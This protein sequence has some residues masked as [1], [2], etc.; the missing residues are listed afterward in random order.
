MIPGIDMQGRVTNW[1]AVK[2]RGYRFA[3][4]RAI[5]E[6]GVLDPDFAPNTAG[7]R[8]VGLIPG[9]YHFI[10]GGGTVRDHCK[11]FKAAIGDPAG[12]LIWIDAEKPTAHPNPTYADIL[13]W[14]D[15][16]RRDFPD[17]PVVAYVPR[18]FISGYLGTATLSGLTPWWWNS[19]YLN[20]AAKPPTDPTNAGWKLRAAG[21]TQPTGWQWHGSID[22]GVGCAVDLN[23]YRGTLE[24]LR[25]LAGL[26]PPDTATGGDVIIT[27]DRFPDGQRTVTG[28]NVTLWLPDGTTQVVAALATSAN[29]TAI[30]DQPT[31]PKGSGWLRLSARPYAGWYVAANLVTLAPAGPDPTPYSQADVD[32]AYA[33]GVA[34]VPVAPRESWTISGENVTL[35]KAP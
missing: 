35:V 19:A 5:G 1:P 20:D 3:V 13:V 34:S 27:L 26:T 22:I 31:S 21:W 15:E 23:L 33:K 9:A 14:F 17:H 28:T 10:A 2:A 24:E 11:R 6:N 29:A 18:W 16:W 30:I 4:S 12:M 7:A 25:A 8:G 32:A